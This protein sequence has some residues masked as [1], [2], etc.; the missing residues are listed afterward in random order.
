MEH[1]TTGKATEG[2]FDS[3]ESLLALV[4]EFEQELRR[5]INTKQAGVPTFF[6]N[7]L[8]TGLAVIRG[9]QTGAAT[10]VQA[11]GQSFCWKN[12]EIANLFVDYVRSYSHP[13]LMEYSKRLEETRSRTAAPWELS[14]LQLNATTGIGE[15]LQWKGLPLFKSAFDLGIYPM[16]IWEARPLTLIELGSGSGASAL[17]FADVAQAF[18]V[19]AHVYSVDLHQ[20]KIEAA[21][22]TFIQGNCFEI[23]RVLPLSFL[24]NLPHPWLVIEDMHKNTLGVLRYFAG[25]LQAK[26]Y[27]IVEDSRSKQDP[28]GEFMKD[29]ESEFRVDT[30]YTDFFGR[31][32]TCSADSIFARI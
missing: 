28:I 2:N 7:A 31:N 24:Q 19:A 27:L 6:D 11:D 26:D 32:A 3:G 29:H 12:D 23:E 14:P 10:I 20:P 9:Q 16:L 8:L 4:E 22:V 15:C 25:M 30:R 17:W 18:G 5:K 21:G 13:R 1:L